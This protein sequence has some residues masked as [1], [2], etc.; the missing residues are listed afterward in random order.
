MTPRKPMFTSAVAFRPLLAGT[1]LCT[2]LL[3]GEAMAQTVALSAPGTAVRIEGRL[4]SYDNGT[5]V[6]ETS[7]GQISVP[8]DG[9]VCEGATCPTPE[10]IARAN[11]INGVPGERV[12][13]TATTGGLRMEGTLI[14]Y[15]NGLYRIETPL[16]PLEVRAQGTTCEG[17]GCPLIPQDS[18]ALAP[19]P[20][21]QTQADGA[22]VTV[23]RLDR[24]P[25]VRFAGPAP[26]L[27]RVVPALVVDL[28]DARGARL[29]MA[30]TVSVSAAD[31]AAAGLPAGG[32][33]FSLEER[34]AGT[35]VV[36]RYTESPAEALSLADGAETDIALVPTRPGA[37]PGQPLLGTEALV[38]VVSP[39]N[40]VAALSAEDLTEIFSG[41]A[42]N[43][44]AFGGPDA[45]IR[46]IGLPPRSDVTAALAETLLAPR[47]LNARAPDTLVAD[48]DALAAAVAADPTAIGF[49]VQSA[50]DGARRLALSSSCGLTAEA[51]PE[52]VLTG[53]YPF[54][55]E[56]RALP[57]AGA[58]EE[59]GLVLA[60]L[61]GA[62]QDVMT[63]A[64]MIGPELVRFSLEQEMGGLAARLPQ[65]GDED[66]RALVDTALRIMPAAERLG[67]VLRLTEAGD[68]LDPASREQ[69]GRIIDLAAEQG[70]A[71]L[72]LVGHA[73]D[74]GDAF[75]SRDMGRAL[76]RQVRSLMLSADVEGKLDTTLL[77]TVG[78]GAVTPIAC[79]DAPGA[80]AS[81][82]RVEI[83]VRR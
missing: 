22:R 68:A 58:G 38:A 16:G 73:E 40:T 55:R 62:A 75:T 45:D 20:Q 65:I 2:A 34:G 42:R 57:R 17:P 54:S 32:M 52:A 80:A 19:A 30:D 43:W 50:S 6:I 64:G 39:Q 5:Y 47:G 12:A 63:D 48:T 15:E 27:D 83:W 72:F 36:A 56:I 10:Q 1:A 82:R 26:L 77:R 3:A 79:A 41:R 69:I 24:A 71:E 44:S 11:V 9:L 7:I 8:T 25:D 29:D 13:L 66:R 28:A 35:L 60:H 53:R 37:L 61:Q 14:S 70:L 67:T 18:A 21:T 81:N 76:A 4:L 78:L 31:A 23:P 51:T 33:A 49:T 74:T 46:V 59:A